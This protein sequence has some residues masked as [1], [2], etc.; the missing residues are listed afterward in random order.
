MRKALAS[1][2]YEEEVKIETEEPVE[3][4]KASAGVKR[5]KSR[6]KTEEGWPVYDWKSLMT[7]LGTCCRNTCEVLAGKFKGQF[8]MDTEHTTF[9]KHVFE[10]L[11]LK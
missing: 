9:Q 8:T 5:K 6:G 7:E 4:V 2:L 10:L 3:P 1:V 11:G